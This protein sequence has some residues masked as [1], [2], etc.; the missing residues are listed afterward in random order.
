MRRR[1]FLGLPAALAAQAAPVPAAAQRGPRLE[2]EPESWDF[3]SAPP[4]QRLT[5]DF[6]LHN[7]GDRVLRIGRIASACACAAAV[8]DGTEVAPGA[9]ATLR[10]TLETRGYR[11]ILERWLT[12]SSNDTRGTRRVLVR[13]YVE[14]AG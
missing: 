1:Q 3:G 9:N 2:V 11:G 10:V 13:V 4:G 8:T 12:I 5:H 7:R 14:A 6:A